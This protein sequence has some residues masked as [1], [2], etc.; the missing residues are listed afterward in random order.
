[1]DYNDVQ[2]IKKL[3]KYEKVNYFYISNKNENKLTKKIT[4]SNNNNVAIKKIFEIQ[5]CPT[6]I[7]N[8]R[9]DKY[10]YFIVILI[11]NY[12]LIRTFNL[13]F[14][15]ENRIKKF[16][17]HLQDI[18]SLL[19]YGTLLFTY[20]NYAETFDWWTIMS[21]F[22]VE[23]IFSSI[24]NINVFKTSLASIKT[25]NVETWIVSSILFFIII[26]IG[27]YILWLSKK[28]ANIR[29]FFVFLLIPLCL[30]SLIF[31]F[32]S[33]TITIHIHHWQIFWLLAFFTQYNNIFIK[34]VSGLCIGIFIQ[35]IS[36]YGPDTIFE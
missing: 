9:T 19:I 28:C 11:I 24:T 25:W 22:I 8:F 32:K 7:V 1:M 6:D 2:K 10:I 21:I 4:R 27:L 31:C 33:E 13:L 16:E 14:Q 23:L 17:N 30:L 34:I 35:G 20:G 5:T 12:S 15:W 26:V 36:T 3:E 18:F 29:I